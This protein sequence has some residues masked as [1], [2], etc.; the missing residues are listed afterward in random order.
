MRRLPETIPNP[1]ASQLALSNGAANAGTGSGHQLTGQA[2]WLQPQWRIG[3]A[4]ART[5]AQAGNRR[6]ASVFAGLRTGPLAWLGEVDA[7]QDDGFPE[8]RRHLLASLA[9]VN[10]ALAR[11]HN[12]KATY[13][14]F[15]PDRKVAQDQQV[16]ASLV[17]EFTPL[18][19]VPLRAGIRR[20]DGIPQNELQN[21]RLLFFEIHGFL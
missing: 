21:R 9:E 3:L 17:Y 11:G 2:V 18:P 10:W 6:V 16:R 8:G 19:F 4:A 5:N 20:Y 7:V 12:L 13:E 1:G 15:D 14:Y